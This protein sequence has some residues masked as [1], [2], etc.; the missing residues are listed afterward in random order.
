M[1]ERERRVAMNE[2]FFRTVNEKLEA[3]NEIFAVSTEAM[4]IVC[5]C[6]DA[7][8]MERITMPVSEY[9]SLRSDATQFAVVAGHDTVGTEVI[10][11]HAAGYHVVR[12]IGRGVELGQATDPRS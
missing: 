8:C 5:E 10:S 2:A 1:D 11:R 4:N 12:K 3:L 6:G 9:E 7:Q